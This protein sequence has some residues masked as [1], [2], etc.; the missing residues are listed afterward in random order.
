MLKLKRIALSLMLAI[1]VF[2]PVLAVSGGVATAAPEID[3]SLCKGANLEFG[4]SDDCT[5]GGIAEDNINNLIEQAINFFSVVIGVIAV[6]MIMI[7][8]VKYITSGGDSGNITT[9]KNTILYAVIG[10]IVVALA[11]VVVKFVLQEAA[12]N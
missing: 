12:L 5:E 9:A 1:G 4:G 11:Q 6:V 8:G 10:L 2:V 3:S 7:G